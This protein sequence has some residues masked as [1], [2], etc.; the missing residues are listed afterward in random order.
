MDSMDK[1]LSQADRACARI[2]ALGH[3]LEHGGRVMLHSNALKPS[4][5]TTFDESGFQAHRVNSPNTDNGYVQIST[6]VLKLSDIAYGRF[7]AVRMCSNRHGYAPRH[8]T[9]PC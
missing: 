1:I 2:L 6:L 8:K 3:V 9:R 5:V 4:Y 7:S